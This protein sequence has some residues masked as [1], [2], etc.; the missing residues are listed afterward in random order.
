MNFS[1]SSLLLLAVALPAQAI[2]LE[3]AWALALEN[4][5]TFLAAIEEQAAGKENRNIA[6]AGLLPDISLSYQNAPEN[7]QAATSQQATSL[8][9]RETERFTTHKSYRSS[10]GSVTLTQPL[11]DYSAWSRYRSGVAQSLMS[12]E[13]YRGKYGDLT[14]RLINAYIDVAWAR[15]NISVAA[16]QKK[17]FQR[18]LEQNKRLF[19]GGEGT[20]TDILETQ[21]RYQLAEAQELDARDQL[22][23][24]QADLSA[25][26]GINLL[27]PDDV[28]TLHG[29]TFKVTPVSPAR[30]EEWQQLML[31]NNAS[32]AASR[33]ELEAVK[34]ETEQYRG[35]FLPKVQLY[36]SYSLS[37]SANDSTVDQRYETTS[38]GLRVSMSLYSGGRSL[39]ATRQATRRYAQKKYELSAQAQTS[40]SE[41]RKN[42]SHLASAPARLNAYQMAVQSAELQ[43]D[44]THKSLLAGQRVNLDI[45]NAEQQLYAARYDLLSSR[46]DYIKAKIKLLN[47]S[48]RLTIKEIQEVSG[49]FSERV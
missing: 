16:A 14:V 48:G 27:R 43:L 23:A 42:Y 32:L 29:A 33:H 36:G 3:E 34:H 9:S 2:S 10:S 8:F 21:A 38:I 15:D 47:L 26:L 28:H 11:F 41:L 6:L 49:Y 19:A 44:A 35:E 17:T 18:Q 1:L 25:M 37:E 20:R 7:R 5:A 13:I 45:L 40:E 39:A 30:Y 4:D 46:Y 31:K 12:S 24:S 22:A